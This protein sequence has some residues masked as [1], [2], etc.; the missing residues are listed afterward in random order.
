MSLVC[1]IL[2]DDSTVTTI[3]TCQPGHSTIL[4]TLMLSLEGLQGWSSQIA[5]AEQTENIELQV[6][7]VYQVMQVG[8]SVDP[9]MSI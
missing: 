7:K 1:M 3:L 6:Y 2:R 9:E 5:T 8:T 4:R